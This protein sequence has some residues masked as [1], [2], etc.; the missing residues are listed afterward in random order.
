MIRNGYFTAGDPLEDG[1]VSTPRV[2][3]RWLNRD[4]SGAL[5]GTISKKDCTNANGGLVVDW[6]RAEVKEHTVCAPAVPCPGPTPT[7]TPGPGGPGCTMPTSCPVLSRWGVSPTPHLQDSNA[8]TVTEALVGGTGHWDSTPRFGNSGNQ[9]TP[10]NDEH[11]EVCTSTQPGCSA[12]RKCEDPR[13]PVWKVDGPATVK[14]T[15]GFGIQV[16]FTGPGKV[17]VTGCPR[18]DAHDEYGVPLSVG[19]N[20]CTSRSVT[21]R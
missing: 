13:G 18:P 5:V 7:P 9:G 2:P 11:H 20:A 12:W 4:A 15:D 21:V 10:C 3:G 16:R 8:R 19:G 14:H 1:D 6:P 17:T